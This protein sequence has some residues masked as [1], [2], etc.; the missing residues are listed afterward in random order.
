MYTTIKKFIPQSLRNL[1]KPFYQNFYLR[2]FTE[3]RFVRVNEGGVQFSIEV[4][5][6]NGAVD[7]YIFIHRNWEP[8]VGRVLREQLQAGGVFVDVGANIGYFSLLA[9]A[10]VGETGRVVSF[11]PLERLVSQIE[12]S[13]DQN[14]Y[15]W[16]KVLPK[17]LGNTLGVMELALAAK[18]IGGSSLVTPERDGQKVQVEVSTLD[19]EL[20]DM[21]KI[22]LMKIDVE[23]FEYEMLLGAQ[24]VLQRYLPAIVLEFSPHFYNQ[25][26]KTMGKDIIEL[27]QAYGYNFTILQTNSQTSNV[28]ELL[29]LING[30]QV[31]LLCTVSEEEKE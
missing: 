5:P 4:N 2:S 7:E 30:Q 15:S 24:Q 19:S 26:S 10:L 21:G 27:L 31:D 3:S 12:R 1:L 11:E 18:N 13:A 6:Q 22:D 25:R 28:D 8:Q 14:S 17:A 9:A 29:R 23:G 16:L 20:R